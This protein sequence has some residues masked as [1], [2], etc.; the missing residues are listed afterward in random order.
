MHLPTSIPARPYTATHTHL[1]V[2]FTVGMCIVTV[3]HLLS[4]YFQLFMCFTNCS[5]ITLFLPVVQVLSV[6]VQDAQGGVYVGGWHCV[7]P[8]KRAHVHG[9]FI[10][11]CTSHGAH[12]STYRKYRQMRLSNKNNVPPVSVGG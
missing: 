1:Q 9:S 4:T 8:S 5:L 7:S 2:V 6:V 10:K 11:S 12:P 3:E